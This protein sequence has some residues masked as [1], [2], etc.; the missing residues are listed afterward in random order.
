MIPISKEE[1][2]TLLDMAADRA[3]LKAGLTKPQISQRQA[4]A[5]YGRQRITAYRHR[6]V[7]NPVKIN[8]R[9]FYS[10]YELQT[11]TKSQP[12]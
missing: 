12:I 9:I 7:L 4:F 1:L 8:G 5:T 2:S 11:V 10:L 6:G 3:L